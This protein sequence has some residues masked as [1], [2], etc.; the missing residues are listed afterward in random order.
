ME[1]TNSTTANNT[2]TSMMDVYQK[3]LSAVSEFYTNALNSFTTQTK[4]MW[5]PMQNQSNSFFNNDAL[6]SMF[7]PLTS[8]GMNNS[9]SNPFDRMV[10]NVSDYNHNLMSSLSK[11]FENPDS[12]GNLTGE[13]YQKFDEESNEASKVYI[14]T[15]ADTLNKQMESTLDTNKKLQEDTNKQF[16]SLLKLSQKFWA[17]VL[18]KNQTP[19]SVP[20]FSKEGAATEIKR[21]KTA[22]K[23]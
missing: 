13:K 3:Q 11:Q 19:R 10:K 15:L 22:V 6:K 8:F 21:D 14:N 7:S 12:D 1:T 16:E 23:V 2:L 20:N 5:N 9:I 18:N 4:N 17:D